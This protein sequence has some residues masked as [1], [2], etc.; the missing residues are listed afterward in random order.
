MRRARYAE[1]YRNQELVYRKTNTVIRN[2]TAGRIVACLFACSA[3]AYEL[4]RNQVCVANRSE[5]GQLGEYFVFRAVLVAR[6]AQYLR[7][8]PILDRRRGR[9]LV[10]DLIHIGVDGRAPDP[11]YKQYV[12]MLGKRAGETLTEA[13]Q[14]N[15]IRTLVESAGYTENAQGVWSNRRWTA[16]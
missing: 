7:I 3:Y 13:E 4:R 1:R 5:L 6:V 10:I 2:H 12:E 11:Q 14:E 8:S 9:I 16:F 15:F